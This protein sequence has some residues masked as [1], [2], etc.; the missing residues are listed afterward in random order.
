MNLQNEFV[1]SAPK[2]D[3]WAGL[4]NPKVAVPCMPGTELVELVGEAGFKATVTLKVGPVKLQFQ[5][6]G[7][8]LNL[9]ADG[10]QG[11]VSARGS[12]S[13][14]RGGFRAT[15]KFRL[16]EEGE[17]KCRVQVDTELALTGSVAQYGRGVGIVREVAA[18]LTNDFTKNLESRVMAAQVAVYDSPSLGAEPQA[19]V[20]TP[21]QHEPI[22]G[23]SL[24]FFPL[25]F[26]SLFRWIRSLV[27]RRP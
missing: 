15:M 25:F 24:G 22:N 14:G 12:D 10:S 1:L 20:D 27:M 9:A 17:R 19:R 8:L 21:G 18:Q 11:E 5:G 26:S 4:T 2:S 3:V 7:E 23:T 16:A 13:K 6:D